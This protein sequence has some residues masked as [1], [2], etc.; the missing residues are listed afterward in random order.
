MSFVFSSI[1]ASTA[2][3]AIGVLFDSQ[4][5]EDLRGSVFDPGGTASGYE[6]RRAH[7]RLGFGIV[8]SEP[9]ACG[10][11][12]G[13]LQA[14]QSLDATACSRPVVAYLFHLHR[15]GAGHFISYECRMLGIHHAG[16]FWKAS[17]RFLKDVEG[18]H[19]SYTSQNI[20]RADGGAHKAVGAVGKQP[21]TS[22]LLPAFLASDRRRCERRAGL[23]LCSSAEVSLSPPVP[24][25]HREDKGACRRLAGNGTTRTTT[26]PA[27]M[28]GKRSEE[29]STRV[30]KA[31]GECYNRL[32]F[33]TFALPSITRLPPPHHSNPSFAASRFEKSSAFFLHLYLLALS[34]L[35][36]PTASALLS[37]LPLSSQLRILFQTTTTALIIC[38]GT[39]VDGPNTSLAHRP[40]S[41]LVV[42]STLRCG[43]SSQRAG[44]IL[45][46]HQPLSSSA[47]SRLP[48]LPLRDV[49]SDFQSAATPTVVAGRCG[50]RRITYNHP[51][52]WVSIAVA[53]LFAATLPSPASAQLGMVVARYTRVHSVRALARYL[54]TCCLSGHHLELLC[55]LIHPRR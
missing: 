39:E 13:S 45:S 32:P 37:M 28:D 55:P 31:A 26:A 33:Y 24:F 40:D 25:R 42:T 27:Q 12:C 36:A 44:V 15:Y 19:S 14:D 35:L 21:T 1:S 43:V 8:D 52:I 29:R 20:E 7:W 38:E 11:G 30:Y 41:T 10:L 5:A 18:F 2:M 34:S 17:S 6:V 9:L 51:W 48:A 53:S 16:L 54:P 49:R 50:T 46:Y 47:A 23:M 4:L 3:R 22:S